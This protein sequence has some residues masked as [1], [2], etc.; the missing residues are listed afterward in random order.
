MHLHL[1]IAGLL[2]I[3]LALIHIGF[4]ERFNWNKELAS[5]SLINRQMMVTHTFFIALTVFLMGLLC[6]TS[7]NELIETSLGKRIALGFGVFWGIRLFI[8]FFGYSS[9][10]W[11]GKTFETIMHVLFSLFWAYLSMLFLIIYFN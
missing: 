2:L 10:L 8:Q 6:L 3:V 11:K 5:L 9:E 4:P 7:S 1:N